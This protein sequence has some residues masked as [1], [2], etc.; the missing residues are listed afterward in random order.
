MP[1]VKVPELVKDTL[2]VLPAQTVVALGLL[3]AIELE[4]EAVPFIK[5][6]STQ[7]GGSAAPPPAV[8][9]SNSKPK[10]KVALLSNAAFVIVFDV[11]LPSNVSS[12]ANVHDVPEL[13]L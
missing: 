6:S 7:N 1:A 8:A 5:I 2:K 4:V 3:V 9:S 13:V 11:Q 12:S 10:R